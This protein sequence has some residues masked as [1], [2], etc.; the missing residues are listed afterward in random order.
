MRQRLAVL[1]WVAIGVVAT[2]GVMAAQQSGQT[3]PPQAGPGTMFQMIHAG[4]AAAQPGGAQAQTSHVPKQLA[5]LLE[6]SE[7]QVGEMDAIAAEACA[8][9]EQFHGRM[10]NALTPAQLEKAKAI[11]GSGHSHGGVGGWFRKL[12]GGN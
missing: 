10:R 3:A 2:I 12:H 9:M 11:H 6:L 1:G 5:T 8:A 7:A 4:C